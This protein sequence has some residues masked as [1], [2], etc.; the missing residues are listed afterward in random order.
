MRRIKVAPPAEHALSQ[1]GTHSAS[2]EY[3]GE[4]TIIWG[5]DWWDGGQPLAIIP[6]QIGMQAATTW[7]AGYRVGQEEGRQ[8]GRAQGFAECQAGFRAL[9]GAASASDLSMLVEAAK[10]AG[11]S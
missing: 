1:I 6:G 8:R 10:E 7:Y 11:E 4:E 2:M 5:D 9:L 3:R